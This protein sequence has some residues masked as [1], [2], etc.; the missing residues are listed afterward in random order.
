MMM[1]RRRRSLPEPWWRGNPSTI[2]NRLTYIA[3][4]ISAFMRHFTFPS[5]D[6]L[7]YE[8]RLLERNKCLSLLPRARWEKYQGLSWNLSLYVFLFGYPETHS[9]K[10]TLTIF[11]QPVCTLYVTQRVPLLAFTDWTNSCPTELK[12]SLRCRESAVSKHTPLGILPGLT[13]CAV[14]IQESESLG[15][16]VH[17]PHTRAFNLH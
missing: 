5:A 16:V 12:H 2:P 13:M 7:F 6:R 15:I 14:K 10:P 17:L 11:Q 1:R 9:P 4:T 3:S 8:R